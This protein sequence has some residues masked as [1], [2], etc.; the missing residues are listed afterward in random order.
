MYEAARVQRP[1]KG[2]RERTFYVA[3]DSHFIACKF[4]HSSLVAEI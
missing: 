1:S 3:D 2:L 4:G